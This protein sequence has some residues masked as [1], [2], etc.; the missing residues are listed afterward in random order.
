MK[1]GIIG[2]G[3]MGGSL[4]KGIKRNI[5]D[6]IIYGS[7][8]S[9]ETIMRAKLLEIIDETLDNK[10]IGEMD[11]VFVCTG[12]EETK[13]VINDIAPLLKPGTM[14]LDVTGVKKTM[15]EFLMEKSN[16]Y[17][18]IDFISLHP[19][20]GREYSG[21]RHSTVNLYENAYILILPIRTSLPSLQKIKNFLKQLKIANVK[22]TNPK[23]HDEMIAY[24]S[25][26]PHVLSNAYVKNELAQKSLGF[27]AGSYR[28]FTRVAQIS[29]KM[30]VP[31]MLENRENI[32]NAIKDFKDN[33]Q[34]LEKALEVNDANELKKLLNEGNEAKL[35][36]DKQRWED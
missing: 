10:S 15:F 17:P 7:D 2:L 20:A 24:T 9:N 1:I 18:E 5:R 8:I 28:D 34:K 11:L 23:E 27:S 30:W 19:M 33:L 29:S 3:L 36:A 12:V 21:L 25:Q 4:A 16:Q 13:Q 26:L 14:C 32:L 6:A 22:I 35:K 31:L